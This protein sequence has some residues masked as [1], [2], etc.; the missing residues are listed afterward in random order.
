[1]IINSGQASV[2]ANTVSLT[3]LLRKLQVWGTWKHCMMHTRGGHASANYS[4]TSLVPEVGPDFFISLRW[5][6]RHHCGSHMASSLRKAWCNNC[7]WIERALST[8]LIHGSPWYE[9][10]CHFT[11]EWPWAW[12]QCALASSKAGQQQGRGSKSQAPT[13]LLLVFKLF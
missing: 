3:V 10:L 6:W 7:V 1:M 11:E 2:I 5:P 9:L 4:H 12:H 8:E 13:L